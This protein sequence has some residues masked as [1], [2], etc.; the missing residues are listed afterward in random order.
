M[1]N[2]AERIDTLFTFIGFEGE[3]LH[4]AKQVPWQAEFFRRLYRESPL[5]ASIVKSPTGYPGWGFTVYA[6]GPL[7][8]QLCLLPL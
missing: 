2:C 8:F 4:S 1:V 6:G 7:N 5:Q 3:E